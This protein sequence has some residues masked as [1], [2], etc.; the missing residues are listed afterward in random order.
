MGVLFYFVWL[1]VLFPERENC[2]S[3]ALILSLV[4]AFPLLLLTAPISPYR[5]ATDCSLDDILSSCA[6]SLALLQYAQL[7]DPLPK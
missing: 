1:D 3:V 2:V 4:V 6:H 5:K 7:P